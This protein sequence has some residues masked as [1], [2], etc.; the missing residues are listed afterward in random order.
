VAGFSTTQSFE[1]WA[2]DRSGADCTDPTARSSGIQACYQLN[3][4]FARQ[5]TQNVAVPVKELLKGL[6]GTSL[7]PNGC[8]PLNAYTVTLFFL[9]LQGNDVAGSATAPISVDTQ[10]P[11]PLSN[12]RVLPGDSA[13]TISWDAVGEGGADDVVGAQAFCDPSPVAVG[14]SDPGSTTVCLDDEGGVVDIDA[15]D[16]TAIADA[17]AT[18]NTT[19]SEGGT[20]TGPIPQPSSSFSSDGI[21]CNTQAFA[22]VNGVPLV[23]DNA[24]VAKYGCGNISGQT[25]SSIRVDKLAGG[26]TPGDGKVIA[27]AMAATD[28]FGNLGELSSPICQFPEQTSDFWRD[29]RNSGGES[30]GGFCSVEGPGVPVGSFSLMCL[31][32]VIGISSLRRLQRRAKGRRNDR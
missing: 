32:I 17:G 9:V 14:A 27:V 21:A 15:S 3:V 25:G 23:A 8:R 4:N 13:V 6:P 7:P 28:S 10:G 11:A 16:P 5:Q 12:I 18:C 24:L 19:S 30:G 20:S 26:A 22:P 2:T 31:G 1:I 29:Y